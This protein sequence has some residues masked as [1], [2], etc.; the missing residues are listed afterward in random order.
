MHL[1]NENFQKT[2]LAVPIIIFHFIFYFS[3]FFFWQT[4]F[5]EY[6]KID[7][8]SSKAVLV[9]F[10]LFVCT[11]EQTRWMFVVGKID[12]KENPI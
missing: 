12:G 10:I 11:N 3:S 6:S 9:S 1:N 8:G 5:R 2:V 4:W 7:C